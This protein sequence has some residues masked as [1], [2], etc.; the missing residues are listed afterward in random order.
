MSSLRKDVDSNCKFGTYRVPATKL[1]F[2]SATSA[3][4]ATIRIDKREATNPEPVEIEHPS[5]TCICTALV[6]RHYDQAYRPACK[7]LRECVKNLVI[8]DLAVNTRSAIGVW[9]LEWLAF[10]FWD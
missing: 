7:S 2:Y 3:N 4:P 5:T 1:L 10:K 9:L 6:N 8:F